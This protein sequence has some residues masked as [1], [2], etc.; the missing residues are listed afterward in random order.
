MAWQ[1]ERLTSGA[2]MPRWVWR[3][4]MARYEFAARYVRGKVVVEC[5]CGNGIGSKVLLSAGAVA[6]EGFDCSASAVAE[7]LV[8]C[9]SPIAHFRVGD[10]RHLP[11]PDHVADIYVAL[12]TIEHL[13]Q[14]RTFLAEVVR[15]L[16]PDGVFVCSTPN[17]TVK[18][19]GA[20]IADRPWNQYHVR[21]Y[22]REEF[23]HLL[24]S[25]FGQMEWYG[26]RPVP[27]R[28]A[29]GLAVVA[30]RWDRRVAVTLHQLSKLPL[31]AWDAPARYAVRPISVGG[32]ADWEYEYLVAVC[33][34]P[35]EL[36]AAVG[37]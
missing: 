9:Q 31:L 5:A 10:A 1:R 30:R 16:K 19:P 6:V 13:D 14:D 2:F 37:S 32:E 34:Q 27:R 17:R 20:S 11:L 26:Q 18:H 35:R 23:A 7:A 25:A 15:V 8:W 22:S 33:R 36:R 24:G 28:T 12:E 3:E 29:E 4:H 21:E